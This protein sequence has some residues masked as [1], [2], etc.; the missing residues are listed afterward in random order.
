MVTAIPH[1]WNPSGIAA[2]G[3]N[4]PS[5]IFNTF[6][7]P[8]YMLADQHR[9]AV[10]TDFHAGRVFSAWLLVDDTQVT[11][12]NQAHRVGRLIGGDDPPARGRKGEI[13]GRA[14]AIF[15]IGGTFGRPG[16]CGYEEGEKDSCAPPSGR[17]ARDAECSLSQQWPKRVI[18]AATAAEII[19]ARSLIP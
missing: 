14:I 4:F 19:A 13:H 9:F 17:S 3:R 15:T 5:V 18:L 16:D 8:E 7:S 10:G 2:V 1:G 6:K 11:G 12:S